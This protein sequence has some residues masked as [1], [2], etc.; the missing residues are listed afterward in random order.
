MPIFGIFLSMILAKIPQLMFI[1]ILD[2][3]YLIQW[4]NSWFHNFLYES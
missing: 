1:S 2:L 3:H 4:I